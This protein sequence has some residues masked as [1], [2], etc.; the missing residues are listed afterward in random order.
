[1]DI[2]G[3]FSD[4]GILAGLCLILGLVLVTFEMFIPGFGI[5]GLF[6]VF[7]LVTGVLLTAR[8]AAEGLF[9]VVVL[10]AIMGI[11]LAV[12]Y[13]MATKGKLAKAMV[14][15][16]SQ[17]KEDGFSGTEDLSCFLNREGVTR[18]ILRPAGRADF[19]GVKLDVVSEGEFI[20]PNAKVKIIKVEGRRIVVRAV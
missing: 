14:L 12:V 13:H 15:T 9:L 16:E 17:Q 5:P 20:A 10:L 1:M 3:M 6:G 11:G 4:A 2:M 19:D 18:T 8:N 7:L